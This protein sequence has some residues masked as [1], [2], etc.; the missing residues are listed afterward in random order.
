M[1]GLMEQIKPENR[2]IYTVTGYPITAYQTLASNI[3]HLLMQE[4]KLQMSD[5]VKLTKLIE[6]EDLE[7]VKLSIILMETL[8]GEKYTK[9]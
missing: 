1:S 5:F 2:H 6:S 7:S 4:G 9:E 8:T 3:R